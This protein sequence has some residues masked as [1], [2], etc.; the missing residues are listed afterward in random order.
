MTTRTG[1]EL[2][3][4]AVRAEGIRHA[5]GVCGHGI[6]GFLDA[7]VEADDLT[8]VTCHDEQVA[9]FMA[10][11]YYRVSRR[12]AMTY[13][14]CGPGSVNL[15]MA[16]ASAYMDCS[17]FLALTGNI[18]TQQFN[19]GPF[20]ESARHHQNDFLDVFKPYVKRG[21]QAFRADMVPEVL[22][23]ACG[24]LVTGRPG[25]V[26]VDVPLNVFVEE[27]TAPGY[28]PRSWRRSTTTGAG[29]PAAVAAAAELL[30]SCA[31]PVMVVGGGA[32]AAGAGGAIEGLAGRLGAPVVTTPLAKGLLDETNPMVLGIT[33]RNGTHPANSAT[34]KADVVVAFGTRFDDRTTS[35]WIDGATYAIPPTALVHIDIDPGELSRNYPAT[36]GIV[37]DARLVA[38]Q[39]LAEL[40]AGP[41]ARDRWADEIALWSAEWDAHVAGL[42]TTHGAPM[43]PSRVVAEIEAGLPPDAVVLADVG[44]HHNWLV[45]QLRLPPRAVLLQSWGF[46]AM[47]FG[48]AGALGA[49]LASPGRPVVAV[50]GDGGLLMTASALATGAQ[51]DAPVCWVVWN[52]G[53]YESIRAQQEAFFG[54]DREVA[55]RFR[56]AATGELQSAD[57]V[58]L[59]RSMHVPGTRVDGPGE[60][61]DAVKAATA[62][63]RPHLVEVKVDVEHPSPSTGQWP[64]PPLPSPPPNFPLVQTT[65]SSR[66]TAPP[67]PEARR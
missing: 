67:D 61:A 8:V 51:L 2:I 47:G 10:D 63:G 33:G 62:S 36:V 34:R 65:G 25:P 31:R 35:G 24:L 20:Q 23:H 57:F 6:L 13:T 59:A 5:F 11:A 29:D 1:A 60:L 27:T 30:G 39:L 26:H 14:S 46:A 49:A 9:G 53:G 56:H 4:D 18:P 48:I 43:H 58:A 55:T 7:T 19:R 12:P 54:P 50:C 44:I 38:E 21:F 17:T 22:R 45:Q 41:H 40:P 52:N 16:L 64:L 37:G 32:V 28:D 15:A 3:V 42:R 66:S